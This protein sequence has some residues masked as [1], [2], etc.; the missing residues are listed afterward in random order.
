MIGRAKRTG[1]SSGNLWPIRQI[2]SFQNGWSLPTKTTI[3]LSSR[4]NLRLL[5]EKCKRRSKKDDMWIF[6]CLTVQRQYYHLTM[7][8]NQRVISMENME[9]EIVEEFIRKVKVIKES[10]QGFLDRD[11]INKLADVWVSSFRKSRKICP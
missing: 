7:K 2:E 6:I 11:T 8:R 3:S 5:K 1:F 9:Q 10:K 4:R